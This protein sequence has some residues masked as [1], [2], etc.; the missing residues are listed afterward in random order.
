MPRENSFSDSEGRS[1]TP[2]LE[3]GMELERNFQEQVDRDLSQSPPQLLGVDAPETTARTTITPASPVASAPSAAAGTAGGASRANLRV[4]THP[5]RPVPQTHGSAKD[6]FRATVHKVMRLHRTSTMLAMGGVGAEPGIDPKRADADRQFG[7]IR[8]DCFIEIIDY[9]GATSSAGRMDNAGFVKLMS[10]PKASEPQPWVKVRWINIGGISWD[11]IKALAIRYNLHPLALEDVLHVPRHSRSKADYFLNHLFLRV[12]CH[13]LASPDDP[14]S[15]DDS[16]SY[17]PRGADQSSGPV[18]PN[19]PRSSSPTRMGDETSSAEDEKMSYGGSRYSTLRE[20]RL[21][22]RRKPSV[23]IATPPLD[24]ERARSVTEKGPIS[25]GLASVRPQSE[26]ALKRTLNAKTV[27]ALKEGGSESR[28]HVKIQP[29]CIFLLRDNTVVS[30]HPNPDLDFTLPISMRLRQP[31]T[32]LRTSADG[33]FLVQS[34]LDLIVDRALEVID[35]YQA[36]ILSLEHAVLLKPH[37]DTVKFL[38]ILQGDLILHRRTMDPIKTV[39][40]GL[41]RYDVDRCAALIAE[42]ELDVKAVRGY[43]SHKAKIYLADVNDHME[44]ILTSLDMFAGISENLINYTFNMASNQMNEVMRQLTL[45][46]VIFLPLTLL[47]GYFGMNFE[48]MWSIKHGHTDL[49]FWI[50][51]LPMMV[52]VVPTFLWSDLRQGLRDLR[53]RMIARSTAQAPVFLLTGGSRDH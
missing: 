1:L 21:S 33:S 19:K 4:S 3:E 43:M 27:A 11:V 47:T 42:P 53:T 50:I 41:R 15:H 35:E 44:Y 46:T 18:F 28:V 49:V 7:H 30:I 22:Y 16:Q 13:S 48:N 36:K 5:P 14:E 9:N 31:Q 38:H 10:D 25:A 23:R 45:A 20:P 2:D 39:V 29:M 17:F 32:V 37:M 40:Y 6:R 51:A 34:L 12:L 52:I 26:A 24:I 8:Q